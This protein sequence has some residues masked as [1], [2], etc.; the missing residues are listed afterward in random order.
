MA[1]FHS[2]VKLPEGNRHWFSRDLTHPWDHLNLLEVS[3]QW[4]Y[5]KMEAF[6]RE[7]PI[8]RWMMTGGTPMDWK[9]PYREKKLERPI[10]ACYITFLRPVPSF[11]LA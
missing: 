8:Y 9:P 11:W 7:T 10:L 1:I 6:F 3:Q 2:Y 5:P 4:G